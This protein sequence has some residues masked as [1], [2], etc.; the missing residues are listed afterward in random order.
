[1]PYNYP[2]SGNSIINQGAIQSGDTNPN[3]LTTTGR[4]F[5]FNSIDSNGVDRTDYYSGFTG[6][7]VTITLTQTGSTA[8]YSGD[9]NSFKRWVQTPMGNGFVF[10]TQITVP[11]GGAAS[12]NATLIQSAST[13][14]N[15]GIPVYVSLSIN[16]AVTPTPTPTNTVTPSIT[17][18]NTPTN[19]VTPSITPSI[20]P[21]LTP[22]ITPTP[23]GTP[24]PVLSNLA[25]YYDPSNSSSY[26][27]TGTTV[28]DLSGNGLNGSMSNISFTSPYFTYNGTNSTV[29]VADNTSLEPGTGDWTIEVWVYYSVIAGSSRAIM[30]KTD[31]GG[32]AANWSYGMRTAANG[33]T[34]MEVGNGTTSV[35]SPSY[36]V[37]TGQW[38]Q[39]VG[40]WTNVAS[41]SIELFVNGVSQGSNS[42]SFTSVKNSSNPLYFGSYNGGEYSQW[43]N[44]R[45][46]ITRIYNS[47]LTS[48]QVSQN[49]NANKSK[50]GL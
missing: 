25:L 39:I 29:S 41:N 9:T 36:T 20:T 32:L 26:S 10:G 8:I 22:T 1:L 5:Y 12:G 46:G 27:G 24:L 14:W 33:I 19:T 13:Q 44:G 21:T 23:S 37:S 40:V 34:Y 11:G 3:I 28:N 47:A 4:G 48:S 45:M 42:H 49:F 38:Y 2:T 30:S 50:Y 17:P 31:N 35:T 16:E 43:F 7:S 15:F 18:T 6:Q